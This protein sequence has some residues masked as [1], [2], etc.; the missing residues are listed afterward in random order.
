MFPLL[1][2]K[3][4]INNVKVTLDISSDFTMATFLK[5]LYQAEG[6]D[7]KNSDD[8]PARHRG[9]CDEQCDE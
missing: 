5:N 7:E 1:N 6:S 3:R 2:I 9:S 8:N 4:I